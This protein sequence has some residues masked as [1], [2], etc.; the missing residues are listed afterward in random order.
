MTRQSDSTRAEQLHNAPIA[1]ALLVWLLRSPLRGLV[2]KRLILVTFIRR[3]NGRSST[4][5]V[6]YLKDGD[7]LLVTDTGVWQKNLRAGMDVRIRW[8]NREYSV[9][10][11]IIKDTDELVQLISKAMITDRALRGFINPLLGPDG[12]P[13]LD[14]IEHA[15]RHN[16]ALIRLHLDLQALPITDGS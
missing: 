3:T 4:I 14:R 5:P 9:A 1:N 10:C 13:A 11:E 7:T 6:S 2:S 8:N 16:F 15:R 12:Y